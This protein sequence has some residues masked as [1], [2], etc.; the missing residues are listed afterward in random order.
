M[1]FKIPME[2]INKALAEIDIAEQN[3]FHFCEPVFEIEYCGDWLDKRKAKYKE[4]I[5]KAHPTDPN[6]DW[7]RGQDV[8]KKCKFIEGK[9]VP[10]K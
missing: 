6:L 8:T 5:E 1:D 9:L 7:G 2:E 4:L 3:G 10:I